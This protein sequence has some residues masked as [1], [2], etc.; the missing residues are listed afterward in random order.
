M[1]KFFT[2]MRGP[3]PDY[4]LIELSNTHDMI[5]PFL[6][7]KVDAVCPSYGLSSYGYDISLNNTFKTYKENR[8]VFNAFD[9]LRPGEIRE[10]D[11][12][13]HEIIHENDAFILP[14]GGFCLAE[15]REYFKMP[16]NVIGRVCDKSTY[17]RLAVAAYHTVLEPGWYGTLTLEL[18]NHGPRSIA[19]KPYCGIVQVMF[20]G[21]EPCTK[22][23]GEH[24]KYQNQSGVQI[25]K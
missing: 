13:V 20:E 5:N 18:V 22:D 17:A 9:V 6:D 8:S 15:S 19:I 25:P 4:E 23:Y 21:C 24:G 2:T 14:P 1:E 3:L 11:F 16:A 7:Y 12:D 10:E